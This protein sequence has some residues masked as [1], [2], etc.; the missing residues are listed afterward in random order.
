MNR[1]WFCTTKYGVV[2]DG[3]KAT[4]RFS[5]DNLTQWKITQSSD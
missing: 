3:G 1:D 4:E 5:L 2:G